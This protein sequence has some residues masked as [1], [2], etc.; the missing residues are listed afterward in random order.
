MHIHA[1][2][3]IT[4]VDSARLVVRIVAGRRSRTA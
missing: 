1:D 2:D 4:K 3:R